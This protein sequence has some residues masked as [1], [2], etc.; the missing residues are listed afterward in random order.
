MGR[1]TALVVVNGD[2]TRLPLDRSDKLNAFTL[3]MHAELRAAR[4]AAAVLTGAGRAFCTGQGPAET[5][6]GT[7][8]GVPD[9]SGAWTFPRLVAPACK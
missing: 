8:G 3:A 5:R 2:V 9:A 6:P 7:E 1:E 4:E